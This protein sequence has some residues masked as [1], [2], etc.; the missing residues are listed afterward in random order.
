[1]HTFIERIVRIWL[2]EQV[3]KTDQDRV[4]VEHWLPVL[5]QNVQAN[6]PL[7]VNVWMVDL[8]RGSMRMLAGVR[9]VHAYLLCALDLWWLVWVVVVNYE[10]EDE[11][12]AF[13]H[14]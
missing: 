4:E 9:R 7:E 14:A 11:C 2:Q 10:G 13:V 8:G 1:M 3:L 12:T 6:V 5:T